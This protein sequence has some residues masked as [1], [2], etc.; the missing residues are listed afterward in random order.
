MSRERPPG[1]RA[2]IPPRVSYAERGSTTAPKTAA[3]LSRSRRRPP[4]RRRVAEREEESVPSGAVLGHQLA[5]TLSMR[6]CGRVE[7]V[8]HA[9]VHAVN[10]TPSRRE[11]GVVQVTRQDGGEEDA[12][13]ESVDGEHAA[14][15]AQPAHSLPLSLARTARTRKPSTESQIRGCGG[16]RPGLPRRASPLRDSAGLSPDFAAAAPPRAGARGMVSLTAA[17]ARSGSCRL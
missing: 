14:H 11:P 2:S 5:V 9:D 17:A 10:A 15:E 6:R 4:P 3:R 7:R 12:P 8:P 16:R 13:A 1:Q